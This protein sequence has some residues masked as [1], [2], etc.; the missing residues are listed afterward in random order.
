VRGGAVRAILFI[1][2]QEEASPQTPARMGLILRAC[3][4]RERD[5]ETPGCAISRRPISRDRPASMSRRRHRVCVLA[6]LSRDRDSDGECWLASCST[7]L[8]LRRLMGS[9]SQSR[10]CVTKIGAA[11]NP[12]SVTHRPSAAKVASGIP[13]HCTEAER[14]LPRR[15]P[16]LR[17]NAGTL[18]RTHCI[19]R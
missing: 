19:A 4:A 11:W 14:G 10:E 3:L 16:G 17:K 2:Q 9:G 5:V 13:A 6:S 1:T 12:R 8:W 18:I 15:P 7:R